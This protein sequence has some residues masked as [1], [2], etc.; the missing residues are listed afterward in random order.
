MGKLSEE[1]ASLEKLMSEETAIC[2]MEKSKNL[3]T[4]LDAQD[5]QN[6]V[7]SA[8]EVLR[9]FYDK[10]ATATSLAQKGQHAQPEI[11]SDEPYQGMSAAKGGVMGMLEVI[12][13]DFVRLESETTAQEQNAQS[14]YDDY[15][16]VSTLDKT[17]MTKTL[18]HKT[19]KRAHQEGALQ[20]TKSSLEGTQKELDAA[21]KTYEK[22]KPTCV[23]G[24]AESFEDR[25]AQRKEEIESL[26]E[27]LRIL[28]GEDIVFMQE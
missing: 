24:G 23:S 28:N 22:L 18:E 8:V 20:E 11:F 12:E 17:E 15:I 6:A 26:Q 3:A 9:E 27:A 13:S 16:K 2:M 10:A 14:E 5:A 1:L 4:I 19:Q 21:L 25:T 7:S